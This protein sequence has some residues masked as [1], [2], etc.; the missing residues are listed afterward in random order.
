MFN[1]FLK[2]KIILFYLYSFSFQNLKENKF[3][4]DYF[5]KLKLNVKNTLTFLI[6]LKN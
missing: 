3:N 1:L 5:N 4:F 6:N 2:L